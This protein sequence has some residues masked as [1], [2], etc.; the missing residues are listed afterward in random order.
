[1]MLPL[2]RERLARERELWK[3][4]TT[5]PSSNQLSP[6]RGDDAG[7]YRQLGGTQKKKILMKTS[8]AMSGQQER[9]WAMAADDG[10]GGADGDSN[11]NPTA[12]ED[13]HLASE[14]SSGGSPTLS[15]AA[16]AA[17]GEAEVHALQLLAQSQE[18]LRRAVGSRD[19]ELV[20]VRAQ[21]AEAEAELQTLRQSLTASKQAAKTAAASATAQLDLCNHKLTEVNNSLSKSREDQAEQE[22]AHFVEQTESEEAIRAATMAADK[23]KSEVTAVRR[24]MV[25]VQAELS[26]KEQLLHKM[27]EKLQESSKH[28]VSA[29]QAKTEMKSRIKSWQG[30]CDQLEA[31][32]K[33][34]TDDAAAAREQ[35]RMSAAEADSLQLRCD[36]MEIRL[37]DADRT[38]IST[39]HELDIALSKEQSL[40]EECEQ[41]HAQLERSEKL[42]T[43]QKQ[44]MEQQD[45][46][47][48]KR[49]TESSHVEAAADQKQQRHVESGRMDNG[50]NGG[51]N[52]ADNQKMRDRILR[53]GMAREINR[54]RLVVQGQQQEHSALINKLKDVTRLAESRGAETSVLQKTL[55]EFKETKA[56]DAH[57][58]K[59]LEQ[60]LR[61]LQ[62]ELIATKEREGAKGRHIVSNLK[63]QLLTAERRAEDATRSGEIE[64]TALQSRVAELECERLR[65][66]RGLAA[67]DSEARN[68]SAGLDA[69]TSLVSH[70]VESETT[71]GIA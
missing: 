1:M 34:A 46:Q 29:E 58:A 50:N 51:R 65:L 14:T 37:T 10:V 42:M 17:S 16:T 40:R 22:R 57:H 6:P 36:Q 53:E 54:L 63:K 12:A 3:Q 4:H 31:R 56:R 47:R 21:L 18:H 67:S 52:N 44:A 19:A 13:V 45:R 11:T 26:L 9:A 20:R 5:H 70:P 61:T 25:S 38:A 7:H 23:S 32:I 43:A 66:G 39:K 33:F 41:L 2:R 68:L 69:L 28:K 59:S 71:Q 48:A 60:R 30:Q 15:Q 49:R 27:D 62:V 35:A 55:V 8:R 64:K 24:E